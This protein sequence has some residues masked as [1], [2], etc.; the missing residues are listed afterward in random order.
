MSATLMTVFTTTI[1][2]EM[3]LAFDFIWVMSWFGFV[4]MIGKNLSFNMKV[5]RQQVEAVATSFTNV[6]VT[7]AHRK[8]QLFLSLES[9]LC[10]YPLIVAVVCI[11]L[12]QLPLMLTNLAPVALEVLFLGF[13]GRLGFILRCRRATTAIFA[14]LPPSSTIAVAPA[15]APGATKTKN[16]IVIRGP[17]NTASLGT[18]IRPIGNSN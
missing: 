1:P 5:L 13:W 10:Y 14:S 2:G 7:P 6:E 16:A 9:C 17:R 18:S 11:G 15:P 4:C 12:S 8:L 3:R